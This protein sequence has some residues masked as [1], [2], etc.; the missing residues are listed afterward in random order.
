MAMHGGPMSDSPRLARSKGGTCGG[1]LQIARTKRSI[2]HVKRRTPHPA[3]YM[4][5]NYVPSLEFQIRGCVCSKIFQ[6]AA[7]RDHRSSEATRSRLKMGDWLQFQG[8]RRTQ[9]LFAKCGLRDVGQ[10]ATKLRY[11]G[12][13][14]SR[15][16]WDLRSMRVLSVGVERSGDTKG[17]ASIL[18]LRAINVVILVID[19]VR[20]PV[21]TTVSSGGHGAV[22]KY[23]DVHRWSIIVE[24]E[25]PSW[26]QR[27]KTGHHNMTASLDLFCQRAT[28]CHLWV[29]GWTE[30][31][32]EQGGR[33]DG[34]LRRRPVDMG[35][36]HIVHTTPCVEHGG[37]DS[38]TL[39]CRPGPQQAVSARV[40]DAGAAHWAVNDNTPRWEEDL[41]SG[42]STKTNDWWPLP[43]IADM[44]SCPRVIPADFG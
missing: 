36:T 35:I 24:I 1:P 30:I 44:P 37:V 26:Q 8:C 15:H 2:E 4:H 38:C 41:R 21:Y 12:L 27:T 42:R 17:P 32:I 9:P 34:T 43:K 28:T 3:E 18:G 25:M 19:K 16:Q 11:A 14:D 13:H 40:W 23:C 31:L 20:S 22:N 5:A 39:R 6:D 33:V 10:A 7:R 29:G